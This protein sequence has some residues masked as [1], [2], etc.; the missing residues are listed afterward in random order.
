M[1]NIGTTI[2]M[3]RYPLHSNILSN[4]TP[5]M[6]LIKWV[7]ISISFLAIIVLLILII[8]SKINKRIINSNIG[9]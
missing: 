6:T 8:L 3:A 9:H 2:V 1:E 5:F 4:I 7:S